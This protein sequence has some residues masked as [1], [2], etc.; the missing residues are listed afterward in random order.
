MHF[1]DDEQKIKVHRKYHIPWSV[2]DKDSKKNKNQ[3]FVSRSIDVLLINLSYIS[4]KYGWK[5]TLRQMKQI[6][7][8]VKKYW[9][10][11]VFIPLIK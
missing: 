10:L 3:V 2:M 5:T 6:F 8:D 7:E 4:T 1:L 11:L 9:Q